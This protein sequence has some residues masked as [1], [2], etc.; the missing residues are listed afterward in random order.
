MA[1]VGAIR[2]EPLFVFQ[3]EEL[4][5]EPAEL[6]WLQEEGLGVGA[7]VQLGLGA[8]EGFVEEAAPGRQGIANGLCEGAVEV[9]EHEDG[10]RAPRDER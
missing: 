9:A 8:G 3:D 2:E 1:F 7:V 4:G 10:P 6:A 5:K